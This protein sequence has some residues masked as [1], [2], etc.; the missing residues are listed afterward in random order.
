VKAGRNS[1]VEVLMRN[2]RNSGETAAV[3]P[4]D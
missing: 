2:P 1:D 3:A 4:Q